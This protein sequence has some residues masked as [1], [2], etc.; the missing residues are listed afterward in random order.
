MNPLTALP[1]TARRWLYLVYAVVGP[2]LVWTASR[3]WTGE[4]EY[5]LWVGLGTALGLV[6]A[7]NTTNPTAVKD[8][9][10]PTGEVAGEAST[11]PAGTPVETTQKYDGFGAP[12]TEPNGWGQG[13]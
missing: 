11:L 6:A 9:E 3:G 12:I 1:A 5:G 13:V 2:V 4:S 7:S 8:D 10:S